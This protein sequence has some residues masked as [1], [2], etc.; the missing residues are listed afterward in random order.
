MYFSYDRSIKNEKYRI[1]KQIALSILFI[2]I[3]VLSIDTTEILYLYCYMEAHLG[4][5]DS[6]LNIIAVNSAVV[7]HLSNPF[8]NAKISFSN[9]CIY[10]FFAFSKEN[11]RVTS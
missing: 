9:N 5:C 10:R 7:L 11:T 2:L 8:Y 3:G 4:N 1:N 6:L